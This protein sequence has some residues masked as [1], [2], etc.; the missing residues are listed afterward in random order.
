MN[1][2]RTVTAIFIFCVSSY[3]IYDLFAC[4]FDMLVLLASISSFLIVHYIWPRDRDE[5]G[6][7]YELLEFIFD[8]PFRTIAYSLRIIG[9][10]IGKGDADFDI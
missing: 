6:T 9:K 7:W 8:L 5:N 10:T 3:L 2:L 1:D 4:G